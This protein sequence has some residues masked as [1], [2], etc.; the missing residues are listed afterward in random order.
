MVEHNRL[1]SDLQEKILKHISSTRHA[2]YDT[3]SRDGLIEAD[4]ITILRSVQA[5][6]KK[7]YVLKLEFEP[8]LKRNIKTIFKPTAKG[9]CYA[10]A[11]LDVDSELALKET[12]EENEILKYTQLLRDV[13]DRNAVHKFMKNAFRALLE[14]DLFDDKGQMKLT[15]LQDLFNTGF[16]AGLTG[17]GRTKS[18]TS[19][20][21]FD[22]QTI[23]DITKMF[24]S[25]QLEEINQYYA[26]I[27]KLLNLTSKA[28]QKGLVRSSPES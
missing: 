21:Y 15:N 27:L 6:V 23:Q 8:D 24:S 2:G 25:S 9:L 4:R 12:G 11:F 22:S 10:M 26:H 17:L 18:P 7:R 13:V 1:N 28:I 16:V 3:L 19:A 14:F 20:L 5:L